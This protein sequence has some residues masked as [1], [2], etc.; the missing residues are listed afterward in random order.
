MATTATSTATR[1]APATGLSLA[2]AS[3]VL[4][5]VMMGTTMPTPL[6]PLYE[7]RFG[8]GSATTT[9]LYAIYAA[10]VIASLVLFGTLSEVVGRRPLLVA[11]LVLSLGSAAVFFFAGDLWLL[12]VGRVLSGL[13]AGI[14]TATG[15]VVVME[16][17][18]DGKDRL[19]ASLA[20]ASNVGGLGLGMLLAG[21][22]A[23]VAEQPL[24]APF[25]VHAILLAAGVAALWWVRERGGR[26][27]ATRGLSLP[28]LRPEARPLF[29]AAAVGAVAGFAISGL[30][31]ALAPNFMGS[32]LGESSPAVMGVVTF[33][34]FGASGFAQISLKRRS[35]RS[36]AQVGAVSLLVSMALLAAA[37][38]SA[39]L[40]LLLASSILGGVGMGLLFMAGMRAVTGATP[41]EDR[42]Q[43]TTAYFLVAYL[44]ISVPVI[45]AGTLTLAIG[46]TATGVVFSALLA[47][48]S[49]VALV[50]VR[51]FAAEQAG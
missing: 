50:G 31:A 42:T 39:S 32:V 43:A 6:Y 3:Y 10:G 19:A 25:V 35:D 48:V 20:T 16:N 17:A 46:L 26:P 23:E 45:A 49:L 44:S 34:F 13:A 47:V 2:A 4:A 24:R 8:F 40:P 37:L 11:G 15:T 28:R 29:A 30:F 38:V 5:V 9:V 27:D 41:P 21:A 18:P 51:R 22:V 12:F 14:L 7:E 36:L 33:L 1:T